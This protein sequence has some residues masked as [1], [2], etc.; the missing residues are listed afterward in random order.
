MKVRTGLQMTALFL[1]G[2]VGLAALLYVFSYGASLEM[3]A[4]QAREYK[5][6]EKLRA[7]TFEWCQEA[8]LASIRD[9]DDKAKQSEALRRIHS[10][11]L[12]DRSA[13]ETSFILALESKRQSNH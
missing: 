2:T 13:I 11:G 8:M 6:Q 4:N 3:S 1:G 7:E 10:S 9:P 12:H 5:E